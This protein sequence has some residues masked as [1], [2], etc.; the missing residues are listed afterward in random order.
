MSLLREIQDSAIDSKVKL[1]D[2]LRKCKVLAARLGNAELSA[3]VDYELNGYNNREDLPEYRIL[4]VHSYGHFSGPFGSGLRGAPIPPSTIPEQLRDLVTTAYIMDPLSSLDSMSASK[5]VEDPRYPWPPDVVACFGNR[6]YENMNCISAW[7]LIPRG[8][9]V[10]I[11][12]TVRNRILS[13]VLE[14]E[15]EAPD[16]GEDAL[17]EKTLS[18]ER[19]TQVF[20]TYIAGNVGNLAEGGRDVSQTTTLHIQTGNFESLKTYLS[21]LGI[22]LEDVGELEEALVKDKE[23]NENEIGE[24]TTNWIAKMIQKAS[25]GL[26]N[27]SASVIGNVLTKAI[28]QYL[29]MQ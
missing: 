13:F 14:I 16:A 15:K 22:P 5:D 6:I 26:L 28:L 10:G 9:I 4:H 12:D 29:G 8:A 17:N 24:G 2:L 23:G 3:W 20:N 27:I 11:I 18:P 21:A 7:Q 1:P 19:I 25:R